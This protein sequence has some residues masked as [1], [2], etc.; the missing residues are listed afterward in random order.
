MGGG[1]GC[2][3]LLWELSNYRI[4]LVLGFHFRATLVA[5]NWGLL[6]GFLF[7]ASYLWYAVSSWLR[8]SNLLS[9]SGSALARLTLCFYTSIDR[10]KRA[11]PIYQR[12][13][14]QGRSRARAA[15]QSQLKSA[16]FLAE[17]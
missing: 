5:W 2:I 4:G 14:A 16:L 6:G 13:F 10:G 1:V 12:V 8:P 3:A 15:Y 9:V 7:G 11:H 17:K